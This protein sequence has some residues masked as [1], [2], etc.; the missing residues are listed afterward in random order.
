LGLTE[1]AVYLAILQLSTHGQGR[2]TFP[3]FHHRGNIG[4]V[5]FLDADHC[6]GHRTMTKTPAS[7]LEQ[8]RRRGDQAAWE[9]F[10]QL[11]TPL[12]SFWARQRMELAGA[13]A[14]DLVQDVF[15][16]LVEKLPEFRYDPQKRFRGW[17]WT[18]LVNKARDRR[19]ALATNVLGAQ[20]VP[21]SPTPDPAD[22]LADRE[23]RG[24]LVRR[25]LELIQDE[26]QPTTWQAFWEC[27]TTNQSAA[28]V[29]EKLGLS[30][31][32]VYQAK[33][34]VLRRLRQDLEGLLD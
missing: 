2:F 24:Y 13:D 21:E 8:L 27:V 33:S 25:V 30:L 34:R 18:I 4:V 20:D 19:R 9:R 12:L 5:T 31:D 32:A 16:V 3:A 17:L 23:Y 1:N 7:L 10:V 15:T 6:R 11:Y 29:G 28:A 14:D 22:E 26:F